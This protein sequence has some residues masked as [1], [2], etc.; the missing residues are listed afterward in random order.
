MTC[1]TTSGLSP[2]L[3]PVGRVDRA[4]SVWH[5]SRNQSRN[6][7]DQI[8][9][10]RGTAA[11]NPSLQDRDVATVVAT[12]FNALTSAPAHGDRVEL[13]GFGGCTNRRRAARVAR[14]PRNGETVAVI[15]KVTS[16]FRA[17]KSL[18]QG[19]DVRPGPSQ[20]RQWD[21]KAPKSVTNAAAG[22][23]T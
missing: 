2:D 6:G 9:T 22:S 8:R 20:H 17:G 11:A 13:R 3:S 14:S 4:D 5:R 18:Q 7:L 21:A 1:A 19:V 23:V 10:H 12:I 15:E 16:F